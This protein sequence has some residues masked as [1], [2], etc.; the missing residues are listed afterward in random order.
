VRFPS[1]EPAEAEPPMVKIP[2][3]IPAPPL[4]LTEEE[5]NDELVFVPSSR[6]RL[7]TP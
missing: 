4:P 3:S 1:E 6:L 2:K 7:L 5:L